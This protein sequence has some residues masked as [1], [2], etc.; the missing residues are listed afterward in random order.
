[1]SATTVLVTNTPLVGARERGRVLIVT[2][3]PLTH[4]Y[5]AA[6]EVAGFTVVGVAGGAAALVEMRRARPHIVVAHT[7]LRGISA[8]ELTHMITS[9]PDDVPLVLVGTEVADNARRL[10]ALTAG[11][12]DYFQLPGE[13]NLLLARTGQLIRFRQRIDQLRAE[14]D[15]DYLTG[16]ANRRRFRVALGQ[17]LERFRRYRVPCAL[18]MVD[19]DFMKRIND[20][21]GHSAGD[22]ALRHIAHALNET[23]RDNDTAARL[24][25]EEFALLLANATESSACA[26]AERLRAAVSGVEVEN[27]GHI[28]ISIGV[29][30]CPSQATSE[31][32]LYAACDAA[33]Y[34]AKDEGR[35][36][37]VLAPALNLPPPSVV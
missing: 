19:V 37:S 20:A 15:R 11:A 5:R 13:L 16:L 31:R 24:G 9:V 28:T 33:L 3:E 27:V 36:R 22:V 8:A 32:A 35:D 26:A 21:H 17:E 10:S 2:D 6:L 23:S 1:M 4:G 29:A 30:A 12:S 18:L 34:R 14:A 25:G 7:S